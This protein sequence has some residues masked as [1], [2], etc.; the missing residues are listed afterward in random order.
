MGIDI[1]KQINN[2]HLQTHLYT[3]IEDFCTIHDRIGNRYNKTYKLLEVMVNAD[4]DLGLL[5][6][7]EKEK[8]TY[9]F[10]FMQQQQR[11]DQI[12]RLLN[13]K[14]IPDIAKLISSYIIN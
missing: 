8:K 1:N 2:A 13:I 3:P 7:T 11:K 4:R 10:Y 5:P 6:L 9:S 12:L 14:N